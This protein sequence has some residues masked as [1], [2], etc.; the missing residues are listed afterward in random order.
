MDYFNIGID[1]IKVII[2][3]E[4]SVI[5]FRIFKSL[6]HLSASRRTLKSN[7]IFGVFWGYWCFGGKFFIF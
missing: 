6:E 1:G 2:Q 3:W 7:H 4:I 5:C